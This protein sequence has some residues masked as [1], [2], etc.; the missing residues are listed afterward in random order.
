MDIRKGGGNAILIYGPY[1]LALCAAS[2]FIF[3]VGLLSV[4]KLLCN[5]AMDNRRRVLRFFTVLFFALGFA[6]ILAGGQIHLGEQALKTVPP[7]GVAGL[8]LGGAFSLIDQD[9]NPVDES[10]LVGHYTLI[11]FGFTFCPAICP[12]ELQKIRAAMDRLGAARAEKILPVFITV[13]PERDTPEVMKA[14]VE[15]FHPRMVG[16]SGSVEAIQSALRHWRVYA[17]KVDDPALSEYTMDHSS[18]IYFAAPDGTVMNLFGISSS[19]AEM[20]A[21]IDAAMTARGD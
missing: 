10:I 3:N 15:Q 14:Y 9:G 8:P 2:F 5:I 19:I 18:Y 11:Y 20:V 12:T 21:A 7:D 1:L 4:A 13:D 17:Q 16:L 6:L